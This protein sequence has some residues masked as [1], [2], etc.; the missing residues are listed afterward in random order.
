MKKIVLLVIFCLFS[1]LQL[2]A[3][4][5]LNN[6]QGFEEGQKAAN[7]ALQ[8]QHEAEM[9]RQQ[10]EHELYMQRLELQAQKERIEAQA[11]LQQQ[12]IDKDTYKKLTQSNDSPFRKQKDSLKVD[13][14]K[15][16]A[17]N[18]KQGLSWL[19]WEQVQPGDTVKLADGT[20]IIMV[21][22]G[23]SKENVIILPAPFA[24][25]TMNKIGNKA[26]IEDGE[27]PPLPKDINNLKEEIRKYN[28]AIVNNPNDQNAYYNRGKVKHEIGDSRGAC[29]DWSKAGE[30]GMLDAYDLI[31]QFCK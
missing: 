27:T 18:G 5:V 7:E 24:Q 29:N 6:A 10:Q 13:V 31:N 25:E 8:R 3:Q 16:Y 11:K 1:V 19:E 17:T 30:L 4:R 12:Q 28:E 22:E 14:E 21:N 20:K 9:L 23:K 15:F 26:K 2:Q